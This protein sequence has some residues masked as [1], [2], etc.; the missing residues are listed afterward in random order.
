MAC[1]AEQTGSVLLI[2]YNMFKAKAKASHHPDRQTWLRSGAEVVIADEGH[3]IKNECASVM[4]W[5]P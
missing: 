5:L 4:S 3:I 1:R 2:S